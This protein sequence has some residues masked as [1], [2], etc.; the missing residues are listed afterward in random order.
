MMVSSK[1]MKN[2]RILMIKPTAHD[3]SGSMRFRLET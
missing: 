2:G 3:A 1:E